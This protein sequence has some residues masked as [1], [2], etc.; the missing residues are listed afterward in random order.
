MSKGKYFV[1]CCWHVLQ[2]DL[3]WLREPSEEYLWTLYVCNSLSPVVSYL[4]EKKKREKKNGFY[5]KYKHRNRYRWIHYVNLTGQESSGQPYFIIQWK[6]LIMHRAFKN[7]NKPAVT[8][9]L[10]ALS[11]KNQSPDL[12]F[13]SLRGG[14]NII[15]I[16]VIIY[17]YVVCL[18]VCPLFQ[19]FY[20]L[21]CRS[22]MTP[23]DMQFCFI[24]CL[25]SP[26]ASE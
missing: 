9:N 16:I 12:N 5:I 11:S 3:T 25:F 23:S 20:F 19:H 24:F 6:T 8:G 14:E 22:W 2:K 15:Y 10:F 4:S 17:I 26:S 7:I 1:V 21:K 13:T 18:I